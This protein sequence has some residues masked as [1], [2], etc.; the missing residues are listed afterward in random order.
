[1]QWIILGLVSSLL[2]YHGISIDSIIGC[3]GGRLNIALIIFR[4]TG[5]LI[6]ILSIFVTIVGIRIDTGQ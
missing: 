1:M 5:F 3:V 4:I 6:S 2:T